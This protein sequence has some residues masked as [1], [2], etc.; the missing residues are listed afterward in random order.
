MA[1]L[2]LEWENPQRTAVTLFDD[3]R[4]VETGHGP[5]ARGA[6]H[7]LLTTLRDRE[8]KAEHVQYVQRQASLLP[9]EG[10]A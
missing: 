7:D 4:P 6:L 8:G 9:P 3:G 10:G 2:T 5:T 1:T